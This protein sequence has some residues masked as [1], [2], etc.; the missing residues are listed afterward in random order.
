M[1]I[2]LINNLYHPDR[3]GG[4]EISVQHLAEGLV[5]AGHDLRVITSATDDLPRTEQLAG[6]T[7]SY[8]R[9]P[10]IYTWPNT[11]GAGAL[12]KL[13]WHWRDRHN[14]AA[15]PLIDAALGSWRPD[16][17]NTNNLAGFS[18][19]LWRHFRERRVP[20]VHTLRDH[21]LICPYSIMYRRG[22]NCQRPCF[23]CRLLSRPKLPASEHVDGVIGISDYILQRHL[24]LGYFP[25]VRHRAVIRNIYD[26]P[27]TA[28]KRERLP[29]EPLVVGFLGRISE[30]KG[31]EDLCEA[32][33]HE[34]TRRPIRLV[35]AGRGKSDYVESIQARH[36][37]EDTEFVGF[38]SP[39]ELLARVHVLA[40]PSRLN[41]G[42]GRVVLEANA[43][44][45]PV[46]VPGRGGLPELVEHGV[47]GWI[48][49]ENLDLSLYRALAVTARPGT[50]S[51]DICRETITMFEK[52]LQGY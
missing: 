5:T 14:P 1:K 36:G 40:V 41:E 42:L 27:V 34:R 29:V 50:S 10:N 19:A 24:E 3:I 4:A 32:V 31:I 43:H 48:Y 20:V 45:V 44:G 26:L 25:Q 2:L 46:L 35:V 30:E 12:K 8:V 33:A 9:Q 39:A 17:V 52:M 22:G 47:N 16:I 23:R 51:G 38:I 13:R 18:V 6:V 49:G 28:A 11:G 21:Y 37:H 7:V 15:G